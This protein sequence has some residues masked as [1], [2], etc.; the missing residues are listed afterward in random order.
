MARRS[1][2][3]QNPFFKRV[4]VALK[5]HMGL[6]NVTEAAQTLGVT[7]A[8]FYELEKEIFGAALQAA[9]PKKRG[10]KKAISN[11]Q[12]SELREQ[13]KHAVREKELLEVKVTHLEELQREM[14]TRGVGILREKK[15]QRQA[16][17][18]RRHRKKIHGKVP[19]TGALEPRGKRHQG[20]IDQGGVPGIGAQSVK[21]L[22]ME[23]GKGEEKGGSCAGGW[24]NR[25][26]DEDGSESPRPS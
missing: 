2:G 17:A 11:P 18:R 9:T 5:V 6:M 23:K 14:I 15:K 21:S 19:A 16:A 3:E 4:E 13:L 8:Y 7:R 10:R 22:P 24:G 26:S 1:E 12:V 20:E 25:G